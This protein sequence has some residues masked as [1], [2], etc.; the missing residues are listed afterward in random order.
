ML[1]PGNKVLIIPN[2]KITDSVVTNFSE[3]E[4][5]R[6]ELLV[7]MPYEESFPRVK[8]IIEKALLDIPKVLKEPA[9]EIGIHNFESHSVELL[10]RPYVVPDDFWEITFESNK[11]IKN[12]L[13]K[14]NVKVAYSEGVELGPIGE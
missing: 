2:S 1:T 13:S 12:A 4:I 10:V 7:T 5:I 11:A 6:L 8:Q 3:K 14:N 9:P